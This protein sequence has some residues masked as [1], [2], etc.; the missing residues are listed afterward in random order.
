MKSKRIGL[1]ILIGAAIPV[2][3]GAGPRQTTWIGPIFVN[4][5]E[6]SRP[7]GELEQ[8]GKQYRLISTRIRGAERKGG[9]TYAAA[10]IPY[11]LEGHEEPPETA[12]VTLTDETAGTEYEREVPRLEVRETGSRWSDDFSFPIT[13]SSYDAEQF[14]LGDKLIPAGG[15]LSEYG[16]ELL[17]YLGLP[18]DC[19]RVDRI[20]WDGEP[21]EQDG[22][23]CRSAVARGQKLVREVEAKYGGQVRTPDIR[24]K[25][26]IGIYE[27]L[28]PATEAEPETLKETEPETTAVKIR[29]PQAAENPPQRP[30]PE[31]GLA[32]RLIGWLARRLTVVTFGT[33]FLLAMAAAAFLFFVSGKR[34]RERKRSRDV[35]SSPGR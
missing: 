10:N 20:D 2:L 21:Y 35:K 14:Y 26:Y 1:L 33:L 9:Q 28:V 31:E 30:E 8:A 17:D 15:E 3:L 6:E 19:Y 11:T 32:R 12:V 13:V 4:G 34:S 22:L 29:E 7:P 23:L 24:G 25:Q 18:A 5:G 27:E 16:G